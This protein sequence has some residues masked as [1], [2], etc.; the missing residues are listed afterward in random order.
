MNFGKLISGHF[1]I[2]MSQYGLVKK[3]RAFLECAKIVLWLYTAR[4]ENPDTPHTHPSACN[5]HECHSDTSMHP[6]DIPQTC[7][8]HPQ[9]YP[10]NMTCQQT[11]KD[12]NRHCQTYSSSTC[13][14]L[15]VSCDVSWRLL[16]CPVS[17]S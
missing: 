15:A 6:P 1:D 12:A 5:F 10:R 9:T 13:Q 3:S 7:H 17:Y 11:T 16:A 14:C 8:R 2:S 4:D